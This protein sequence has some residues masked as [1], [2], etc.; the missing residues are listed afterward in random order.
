MSTRSLRSNRGEGAEA[1]KTIRDD[2]RRCTEM[3]LGHGFDVIA[4]VRLDGVQLQAL[5]LAVIGRF[6]RHGERDLVCPSAPGRSRARFLRS[7]PSP[8]QAT[9][10]PV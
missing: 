4:I 1:G 3:G 9:R 7:R 6:N 10:R 8:G 5:R 2:R